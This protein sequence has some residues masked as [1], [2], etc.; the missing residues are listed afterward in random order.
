M[1]K[2][3]L[4]VL[5]L[6][7]AIAVVMSGCFSKNEKVS[8]SDET[9]VSTTEAAI[10]TESQSYETIAMPNVTLPEGEGYEVDG[11]NEPE[12]T[13]PATQKPTEHKATEPKP[14]EPKPT[15]PKPTE[16]IPTEPPVSDGPCCEYEKYLAMSPAEQESYVR[17]F[18]DPMAFIQWSQN[19]EAEHKAHDDTINVEGGDLNIGDFM[20]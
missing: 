1:N 11:G 5:T 12:T 16:P 3:I 9:S 18:S 14:T 20:K 6:I 8:V 13:R 4:K 19:A 17:T 7:L 10:Q 15:E 2:S